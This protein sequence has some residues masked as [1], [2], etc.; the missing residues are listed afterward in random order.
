[1]IFIMFVILLLSA[2]CGKQLVTNMVASGN[3]RVELSDAEKNTYKVYMPAGKDYACNHDGNKKEDRLKIFNI[4]FEG[5]CKSLEVLDESYI[6][7]NKYSCW[8]STV[9]CQK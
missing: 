2:C 9:K 3:L 1:M 4:L 6:D 8:C 5:K 7:M